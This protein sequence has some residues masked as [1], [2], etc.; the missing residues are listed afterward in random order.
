MRGVVLSFVCLLIVVFTI[1]DCCKTPPS[2]YPS[3]PVITTCELPPPITVPGVYRTKQGCPLNLVCYDMDNA[4]RLAERDSRMKQ[5]I[6]EARARCE[7]K[8][9]DAGIIDDATPSQ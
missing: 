4:A 6:R 2:E 7:V 8:P 9:A 5:W 1:A 3:P